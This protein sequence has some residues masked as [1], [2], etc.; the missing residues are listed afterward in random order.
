MVG[1]QGGAQTVNLIPMSDAKIAPS[2]GGAGLQNVAA[3]CSVGDII[4]EIGHNI[5]FSHEQQRSDRD[6]FV[7][8]NAGGLKA[9]F[10]TYGGGYTAAPSG[11]TIDVLPFDYGSIME[12]EPEGSPSNVPASR[13][14]GFTPK[15]AIL[16]PLNG[17]YQQWKSES[18]YGHD[19]TLGQ[20]SGL[21]HLD[22]KSIAYL[23]H[24]CV[25]SVSLSA[26]AQ[27]GGG[28]AC[29]S[30]SNSD[31]DSKSSNNNAGHCWHVTPYGSC[32]SDGV[33]ASMATAAYKQ[34]QAF[35]IDAST[36]LCSAPSKCTQ[37]RPVTNEKCLLEAKSQP[38]YS[39]SCEFGTASGT[40]GW[41]NDFYTSPAEAIADLPFVLSA[42]AT[43][44]TYPGAQTP[45]PPPLSLP[46]KVKA[47]S[48]SDSEKFGF[49]QLQ[50]KHLSSAADPGQRAALTS[51]PFNIAV[52]NSSS[53]KVQVCVAFV[54][55]LHQP[56]G[57]KL[58][59]QHAS[60]RLQ[61]GIGNG[62]GKQQWKSLWTN[63]GG[64]GATAM[65][66]K[67]GWQ[68]VKVRLSSAPT[69]AAKRRLRGGGRKLVVS[70]SSSSSSSS[71]SAVTHQLRFI[72]TVGQNPVSS[73]VSISSISIQKC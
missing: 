4:H 59:L 10:D 19:A 60:H 14:A 54:Y 41:Q 31:S 38:N 20:K 3:G 73:D 23:Y 11:K 9:A 40:C 42:G 71:N 61:T 69:V 46:A 6:K 58:E 26:T 70:G 37:T 21:S 62:I 67:D 13:T 57:A 55:R 2:A 5:G 7:A 27:F 32:N 24:E 44:N 66:T 15:T 64:A 65:T 12:Y 36:G 49:V 33:G 25:S 72:A 50:S 29:N 30:N 35:C 43:D 22:Q 18:N 1:M 17:P 51:P 48:D 56:S 47:D 39:V 68:Q 8:V 45:P 28:H 53:S 63:A 16:K 34:R 52:S